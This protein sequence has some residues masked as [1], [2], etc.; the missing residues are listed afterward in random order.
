MILDP[1]PRLL[2]GTRARLDGK[3]DGWANAHRSFLGREH[4]MNDVDGAFGLEVWGGNTEERIFLEYEP[5]VYRTRFKL[6]RRFA[7]V[8]MFDRKRD[9]D[10]ARAASVSTAF[11]LWQARTL[12]Q[13]QPV[14]GKFFFVFGG[15]E[16]PWTLQELDI[17]T[18]LPA[19]QPVVLPA[20]DW[21]V[22]WTQIGLAGL[23]GQL[24]AHL[25]RTAD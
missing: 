17:Q 4:L 20:V 5:D 10:A 8:A 11:Y 6:I 19:G 22:I 3:G 15:Q 12:S 21:S 7:L 24:R 25:E 13:Q 14:P 23:R 16:P 18:G 1:T 9:S 2:N